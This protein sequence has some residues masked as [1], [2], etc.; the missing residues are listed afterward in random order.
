MEAARTH[1]SS[2]ILHIQ[3]RTEN[4]AIL[5]SLNSRS[6]NVILSFDLKSVSEKKK[7]FSLGG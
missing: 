6:Q 2:Q 7:Q 1:N 3:I 5:Q 4:L